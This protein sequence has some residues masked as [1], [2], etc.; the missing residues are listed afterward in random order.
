M[1]IAPDDPQRDEK[2]SAKY[3]N[4]PNTLEQATITAEAEQYVQTLLDV[5]RACEE[6]NGDELDW[7][8]WELLPEVRERIN[9]VQMRLREAQAR[10][11]RYGEGIVHYH[12]DRNKYDEANGWPAFDP[13]NPHHQMVPFGTIVAEPDTVHVLRG[14]TA[15]RV[16]P[17]TQGWYQRPSEEAR[18]IGLGRVCC[19][20]R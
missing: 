16:S 1:T 13:D 3:I 9:Q 15:E 4:P 6:Y 17:S 10:D 20:I 8:T 7:L 5:R 11:S 19:T 14:G 2:L 12:D 18:L